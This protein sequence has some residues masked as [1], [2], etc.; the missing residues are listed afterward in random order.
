MLENLVNEFF[1]TL[2]TSPLFFVM[3]AVLVIAVLRDLWL[4]FKKPGAGIVKEDK[5]GENRRGAGE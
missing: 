2:R 3:V 4:G 1:H 5:H